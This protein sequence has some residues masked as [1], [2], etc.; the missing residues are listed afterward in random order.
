[1]TYRSVLYFKL[2]LKTY[3][4]D[5]ILSDFW[6]KSILHEIGSNEVVSF[7]LIQTLVSAAFNDAATVKILAFYLPVAVLEKR[8]NFFI[9]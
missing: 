1:M 8:D 2:K 5:L 6:L 3:C 7:F 9:I 4:F